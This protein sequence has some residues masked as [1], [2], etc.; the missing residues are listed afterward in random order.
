MLG[1]D[2]KKSWFESCLATF[3]FTGLLSSISSLQ[4]KASREGEP[5]G[6]QIFKGTKQCS[7][8]PQSSHIHFRRGP[9]CTAGLTPTACGQLKAAGYTSFAL[10]TAQTAMSNS[11][12]ELGLYLYLE[13]WSKPS[14]SGRLMASI[15]WLFY[16]HYFMQLCH[17]SSLYFQSFEC[18]HWWLMFAFNTEMGNTVMLVNCQAISNYVK[19]GLCITSFIALSS[20][21]VVCTLSGSTVSHFRT[22][23]W[24]VAASHLLCNK[25]C[26]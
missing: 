20:Y 8:C 14:F 10:P 24:K 19:E 3:T 18:K 11:P 12:T 2:W 9:I 22:L 26:A 5:A 17:C 1:L 21:L 7:P 16:A 13:S 25:Q 6:E 23:F 15:S 4:L